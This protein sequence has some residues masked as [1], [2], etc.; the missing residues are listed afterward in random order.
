MLYRPRLIHHAI[1]IATM[2]PLTTGASAQDGSSQA[3]QAYTRRAANLG[4]LPKPEMI[5]IEDI[6]NYHR[7]RLPLPK[8]GAGTRAGGA[9]GAPSTD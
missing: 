9:V 6:I 8:G 2:M 7:H 5:V 3:G 1:I 4:V